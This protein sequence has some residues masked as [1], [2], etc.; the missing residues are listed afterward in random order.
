ME[1]IQKKIIKKI[2]QIETKRTIL[3]ILFKIVIGLFLA[4]AVFIFGE[5]FFE[6]L[7]EEKALDFFQIFNED[8]EVIKKYFFE[9]IYIF[10]LEIPKIILILFLITT[11]IFFY[12]I[13]QIIKNYNIIKNKVISLIKF[14][15]KKI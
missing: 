13:W 4:T 11:S 12:L 2:Y 6:I 3:E 8:F 15:R 5:I 10:Y 9:V 7:K 1:R 14:W